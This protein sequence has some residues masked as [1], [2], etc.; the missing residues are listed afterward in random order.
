MTKADVIEMIERMPDNASVADIMS[1][2]YARQKIELGQQQ[3]DHGETINHEEAKQRLNRWLQ[4][5]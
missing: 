4:C 2:L 1:A 5:D 3:A